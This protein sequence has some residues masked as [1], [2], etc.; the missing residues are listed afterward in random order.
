MKELNL[1]L[2]PAYDTCINFIK[3]SLKRIKWIMNNDDLGWHTK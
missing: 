2:I 3:D 1:Q